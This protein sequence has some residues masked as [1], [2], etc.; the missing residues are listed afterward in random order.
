MVDRNQKVL[1]IGGGTFGLSTALWLLRSRYTNVTVI[2]S[3]AL[4]SQISAGFDINKIVQSCYPEGRSLTNSL[5]IE[6]LEGW[7]TDPVFY[8]HFYETGIVYSTSQDKDSEEYKLLMSMLQSAKQQNRKLDITMLETSKD[9]KEIAPQLTGDIKDWKGFYQANECGWVH[10]RDALISAGK[11]IQRLGGKYIV[12]EVN[13]LIYNEE[14]TKVLGCTTISGQEILGD[15]I[16]ISAGASSV[17]IMDF[18]NQLL[19]KCWTVGHIRLTEQEAASFKNMPVIDNMEKGFFFEPDHLKHELK[20]CNEFPGYTNY[21]NGKL[22]KDSVPFFKNGIP[23][24]A[25][26]GIRDILA[27]TLPQFKDRP[28]VETKICWCT[29]TPDRNFLITEHPKFDGSLILATGDSGHGFKH[30]PTIGRY[31]ARLISHGLG[32]LDDEKRQSWRWRPE[33]SNDRIQDR[34]GGS[35]NVVDLSEIKEWISAS[36]V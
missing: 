34:F 11:E 26:D 16:V 2:D 1:I 6:A 32:S 9:F 28:F 19:A 15:K 12:G 13:G 8:P 36:L 27:D 14:K 22:P 20:I 30:M 10:A 23:K 17:K 18:E 31:V 35:G 4:P 29:D 3:R 25:E 5:A 24:E 7:Q 33:T 21:E